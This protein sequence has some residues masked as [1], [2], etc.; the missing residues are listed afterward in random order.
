MTTEIKYYRNDTAVIRVTIRSRSTLEPID[1]T[2]KEL[3][4]TVDPSENP[5]DDSSNLVQL[6][7]AIEDAAG[8][9][10]T[11]TP[12]SDDMDF[13]PGSYWYDV[14]IQDSGGTNRRTVVKGVFTHQQDI[15]K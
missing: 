8:G 12:D 11:F 6:T 2:A 7:G 5:E 9:V 4:L 1:I 10:A 3:L 13:D 15:T 14:Q